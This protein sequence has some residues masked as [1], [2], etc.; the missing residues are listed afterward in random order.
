MRA[1]RVPVRACE[2]VRIYTYIYVCSVRTR[3]P[4]IEKRT[5]RKRREEEEEEE[6]EKETARGASLIALSSDYVSID[7]LIAIIIHRYI[8]H[9][10]MYY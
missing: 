8:I 2:S 1:S 7:R 10:I 3:V 5:R 6:K 4:I 9:T